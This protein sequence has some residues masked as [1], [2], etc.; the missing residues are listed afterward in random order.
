MLVWGSLFALTTTSIPFVVWKKTLKLFFIILFILFLVAALAIVFFGRDTPKRQR[1]VLLLTKKTENSSSSDL[2]FEES[3]WLKFSL[4]VN[5]LTLNWELCSAPCSPSVN[6]FSTC[7]SWH[8]RTKAVC[9]FSFYSRWL[10]RSFHDSP[11]FILKNNTIVV[12]RLGW[13]IMGGGAECQSKNNLWITTIR[14]Y[15]IIWLSDK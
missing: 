7:F 14:R 1:F 12:L 11:N 5:R 4:F 6:Y 9:S 3:T 8:S 15:S 13:K 10:I 2:V